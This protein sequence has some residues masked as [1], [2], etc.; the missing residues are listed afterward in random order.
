MLEFV[1][2]VW[3]LEKVDLFLFLSFEILGFL[4]KKKNDNRE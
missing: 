4:G 2:V 3:D 1:L